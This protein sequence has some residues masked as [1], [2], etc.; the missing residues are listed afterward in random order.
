MVAPAYSLAIRRLKPEDHELKARLGR[1]VEPLSQNIKCNKTQICP[2]QAL[3]LEGRQGKQGAWS[4]DYKRQPHIQ[5]QSKA[6]L[7]AL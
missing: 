1:T 4:V 3:G 5:M 2:T 6:M 7:A